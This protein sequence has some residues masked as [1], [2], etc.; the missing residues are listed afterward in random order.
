MSQAANVID[1]QAYRDA[2]EKSSLAVSQARA[3]WP[4]QPFVMWVPYLGFIPVMPIGNQTY[5]G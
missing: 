2:R 5:G 1:F 3:A 4:A